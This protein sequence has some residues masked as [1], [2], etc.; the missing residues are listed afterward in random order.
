VYLSEEV[1]R[2]PSPR[3]LAGTLC[4]RTI[5]EHSGSVFRLQFDEFQMVSS[6]FIIVILVMIITMP[7]FSHDDTYPASTASS[8]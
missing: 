1:T 7:L 8:V 5:I 3:A 2:P 6:R 4:I